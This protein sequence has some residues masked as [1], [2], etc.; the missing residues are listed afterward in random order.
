MMQSLAKKKSIGLCTGNTGAF[1]R[2]KY[3]MSMIPK[4]DEEF[5]EDWN[6]SDHRMHVV[7]IEE[8]DMR[9]ND[10]K[11]TESRILYS[12]MERMFPDGGETYTFEEIKRLFEEEGLYQ[13]KL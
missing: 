4:S 5:R 13:K 3:S 11:N 12:V 1:E 7:D 8:N 2:Y 6:I 10:Y 9:K